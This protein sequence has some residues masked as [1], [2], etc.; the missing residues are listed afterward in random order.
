[1]AALRSDT[2]QRA[3]ARWRLAMSFWEVHA[4][5]RCLRRWRLYSQLVHL[6][7]EEDERALLLGRCFQWWRGM[8][9]HYRRCVRDA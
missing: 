7:E 6:G 5:R 2:Q 4:A 1:M 9:L 8:A 3:V